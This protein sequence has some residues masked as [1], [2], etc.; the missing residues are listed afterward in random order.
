MDIVSVVYR[1]NLDFKKAT[2]CVRHRYKSAFETESIRITNVR[3]LCAINGSLSDLLNSF[4]MTKRFDLNIH[5]N[6]FRVRKDFRV[7]LYS[8]LYGINLYLIR[9]ANTDLH[10]GNTIIPNRA[11]Q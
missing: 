6:Y 7:H 5:P 1:T 2:L 10:G 8:V 11:L 9:R 4:W 3:I